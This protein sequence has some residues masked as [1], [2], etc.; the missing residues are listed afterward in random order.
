MNKGRRTG[1]L[2]I[3]LL[4]ALLG[5]CT[6]EVTAPQAGAAVNRVVP[7]VV[8]M[9][10]PDVWCSALSDVGRDRTAAKDKN[11]SRVD[12]EAPM[13]S[14]TGRSSHALVVDSTLTAWDTTKQHAK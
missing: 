7:R 11:R 13:Q 10:V 9:V 6:P 3:T 1:G 2:L 8:P 12:C 14:H 4:A 5:A